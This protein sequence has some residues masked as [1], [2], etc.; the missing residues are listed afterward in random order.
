MYCPVHWCRYPD[1]WAWLYV[2]VEAPSTGHLFSVTT[3]AA[4]LPFGSA[5]AAGTL[6]AMFQ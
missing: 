6:M 3:P 4:A 2:I 1:K 5:T